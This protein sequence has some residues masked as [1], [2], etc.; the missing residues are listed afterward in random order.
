[1]GKGYTY[2]SNEVF[3]STIASV[4]GWTPNTTDIV[5]PYIQLPVDGKLYYFEFLKGIIS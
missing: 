5:V 2:K 4:S 3:T 1:M